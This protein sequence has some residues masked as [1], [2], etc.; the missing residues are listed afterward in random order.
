M[1]SRGGPC[2]LPDGHKGAHASAQGLANRKRAHETW[3][4]NSQE[5]RRA[6]QQTYYSANKDAKRS[7][8]WRGLLRRKYGLTPEEY[9]AMVE[10]QG[11]KCAICGSSDNGGKP[12]YVD[13]DHTTG[14]NRELL[15]NGCNALLGFAKEAPDVLLAAVQYLERHGS[16]MSRGQ[17]EAPPPSL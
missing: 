8:A 15:C 17:E 3:A 14:A 5:S 6:Y 2:A 12:L 13:H 7:T 4:Q 16:V 10:A 1:M 11:G 9:A